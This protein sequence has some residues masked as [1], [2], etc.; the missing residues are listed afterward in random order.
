MPTL[1]LDR[2]GVVN[3]DFGYVGDPTRFL[4]IPQLFPILRSLTLLGYKTIMATNQSGIARGYYTRSD[5]HHLSLS[6]A[7]SLH[8]Y[9]G[10]DIEVRYCPH[11]PDSHCRCRKPAPG[12][13]LEPSKTPF[14]IFIG[15][16]ESDMLAAQNA[17]IS[18]RWLI[19]NNSIGP[20][21]V[22]FHNHDELLTHVLTIKTLSDI[23]PV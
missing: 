14:D 2:D 18:N 15:D 9:T 10:A 22:T 19:G 20:H 4:F 3:Y 8:Y 21:T 17:Q 23:F 1:Y 5:F 7:N 13:I 16:N 6:I 12:L 11:L